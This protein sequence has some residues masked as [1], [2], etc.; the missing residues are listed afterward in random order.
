MK[1]P[2]LNKWA[3][4]CI[5]LLI[6]CFHTFCLSSQIPQ[7]LQFKH[8]S[9][10][11]GLPSSFVNCFFKDA[12]GFLWLGTHSGG[13][14]RFDGQRLKSYPLENVHEIMGFI[15]DSAENLYVGTDNGLYVL[16]KNASN[17]QPINLPI[18]K[19]KKENSCLI[20]PL[21]IDKNNKLWLFITC[22]WGLYTLD[23][24]TLAL[25]KVTDKLAERL[26][27]Y[28]TQPYQDV[29]WCV[30]V[31]SEGLTI[32]TFQN[33]TV[34]ESFTVLDAISRLPK[35]NIASHFT[36][37]NDSI[38]WLGT[39]LGLMRYNRI[40]TD[41]KVFNSYRNQKISNFARPRLINNSTLVVGTLAQGLFF[42][43]KKTESFTAQFTH[44]PTM[45]KSLS[46]NSVD[47]IWVDNALNIFVIA[48]SYGVDYTSLNAP[49]FQNIFTKKEAFDNGLNGNEIACS[50][51]NAQG[52]IYLGTKTDGIV[53]VSATGKSQVFKQNHLL[54]NK[55]VNSILF[56]D[57]TPQSAIL[58]GTNGGLQL[59]RNGLIK[60]ILEHETVNNITRHNAT[61]FFISTYNNLY[62]LDL[63]SD[64]S[65][66]LKPVK[67]VAEGAHRYNWNVFYNAAHTPFAL[68]EYG[69]LIASL[70]YKNQSWQMDKSFWFPFSVANDTPSVKNDIATFCS[71]KGLFKINLD[72]F[73]WEV[74]SQLHDV[75]LNQVKKV[76]ALGEKNYFVITEKNIF[77]ITP[78]KINYYS[79]SDGLSASSLESKACFMLKNGSLFLSGNNGGNI[80]TSNTSQSTKKNDEIIITDVILNDSIEVRLQN[81]YLSLPFNQNT[82]TISFAHS[83]FTLPTTPILAYRLKNFDSNWLSATPSATVRYSNLPEGDYVFEVRYLDSD[84]VLKSVFISI[85]PPFYRTWWF[86]TL[87]LL[88]CIGLISGIIFSYL[89]RIKRE[90]KRKLELERLKIEAETKA[91]R[92]QMNPHFIFN[93]INTI[94]GYIVTNRPI[95]ASAYLQKFSKLIRLV[96]E[97][98]LHETVL[99]KEDIQA[100][101]LYIQ[102]EIERFD[103]S[104]GYSI[105]I[106]DTIINKTLKIPPL[107]IQ[108]FVENAILHG[109]RHKTEGL[110]LVKVVFMPENNFIRVAID[111]NGIGR[112]KAQ[113]LQLSKSSTH[114]SRGIQV[115]LDRIKTLE[116]TYN[117]DA[118]FKIIDKNEGGTQVSFRISELGT[119]S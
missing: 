85:A 5:F 47:D 26:S 110:G 81:P 116:M 59:F 46:S 108:P 55:A 72:N 20:N 49:L 10:E 63:K 33:D 18:S 118:D 45:P 48:P 114:I 51:E 68:L 107:L 43:D 104:F 69:S 94:D 93:C 6:Y 2:T 105:E 25:N 89:N 76:F 84:T 99:I 7:Q 97:N 96:L 12:T 117:Y 86:M 21:Y 100:L 61:T 28:P 88:G 111:D 91:L 42:F 40:T 79:S 19:E 38:I 16:R 30:S 27:F 56:L 64:N 53:T 73:S 36:I 24:K 13:L 35:F 34:K 44:H 14:A 95:L 112:Q 1:E 80:F 3:K 52:E 92:A 77:H 74:Q 62:S 66:S 78:Q 60:N 101:E 87:V 67:G 102:L 22:Q 71:Y 31:A 75:S 82:L 15:K 106:H 50:V 70:S 8:L 17:F 54:L 4:K 57:N 115:T 29:K 90:E 11:S 103:N 41:L 119:H 23:L 65:F 113:Q 58:V 98:S 32:T 9:V 109:L 39:T 37:E 83:D